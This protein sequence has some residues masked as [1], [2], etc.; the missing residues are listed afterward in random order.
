MA[1]TRATKGSSATASKA[2]ET[3]TSNNSRYTLPEESPNP[4]RL[5]VLP[6][7]ATAEARVATLQNPRHGQPARY[8]VCPES[9]V[10]E[11]TRIA[12]PKSTPRSWLIE[13]STGDTAHEDETLEPGSFQSHI[14]KGADL[15][16]ATPI[17]PLFLL[18]PALAAKS[19]VGRSSEPPK[20]MFLTSDDHFDRIS[21]SNHLSDILRLGGTR[22]L[23]EARMTAVCDTLEAGDEKMFRL[24][25]AKLLAELLSKAKR[26]GSGALPPSMEEKFVTKVL[27][28][29]IVG[30]RSTSAITSGGADAAERAASEGESASQLDSQ[31]S[32]TS[33]VSATSLASEASSLSTAATSVSEESVSGGPEVVASA[34]KASPEVVRLQRLRVAFNFICASYIAPET[35]EQ[36]KQSIKTDT[37]LVD[38]T[39]LDEYLEKL[40][41]LRQ[42]T[43]ELRSTDYSLKRARDEE[44]DD[45]AEKKRKKDEEDK[46]KKA[47]E[48]R[49]VRDL[50]KVNTSGMKKMSDFFK[51]K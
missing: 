42:E 14:S 26:M 43:N 49:G 45:R 33:T 32:F 47:N 48:S 3:A 9:G 39:S 27:E 12:A 20:R 8:L 23:F 19:Q 16:I 25:E 15:Y 1:R 6:Q 11:F 28:A 4:P 40:A 7:K 10:Y 31:A 5:F 38:F 51:K 34:I 44:D 46:R 37:K 18:L 50:K 2:A 35:A 21:E 30:V 41:K 24:S 17:D 36:L 29:P 13:G 22:E